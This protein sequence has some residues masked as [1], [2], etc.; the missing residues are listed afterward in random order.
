[1]KQFIRKTIILFLMFFIILEIVSRL[2]FDRVYFNTINIY[3]DD[4]DFI[5]NSESEHVD[6]LFL[7]SS[8][9][10]AT[11]NSKLF[12]QLSNKT[13]INVGRGW[14]TSG[15]HIKA[16]EDKLSKSPHFLKNSKVL[17]EYPG[18]SFFEE[19][20]EET[21]FNVNENMPHLILPYL[22]SEEFLLFLKESN[23]SY[24][25]K[26]NMSFLFL[27]STYRTYQYINE[28]WNRING[29]SLEENKIANKG[30]IRNDNIEVAKQYAIRFAEFQKKEIQ[31]NPV[32]TK[33]ALD[34]SSL[35]KLL[36]LVRKNKGEL[37]L[38]KMPLHSLQLSVYN[39]EKSIQNKKVF[40]EWLKINNVIVI[41]NDQFEFN[42]SDF[43]DTWHLSITRMDEFTSKLYSKMK[44]E[45]L[46][47]LN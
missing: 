38:Y 4:N 12:S 31:Q 43:P 7:G 33:E 29:P 32:L 2:A 18:S 21:Q 24:K 37:L 6:I 23:N 8:R 41:E 3:K 22:N 36:Q 16:L 44:S 13:V 17:I 26:I 46:L 10:A 40:Q 19:C 9:V 34:K 11:I 5:E 14:S 39:N 15:I 27:S 47:T 30:G 1:M 28:K 25:V 20:Y 35:S 45:R 42:D